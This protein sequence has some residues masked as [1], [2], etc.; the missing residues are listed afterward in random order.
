MSEEENEQ[1]IQEETQRLK[2]KA[3]EE[4]STLATILSEDNVTPRRAKDDLDSLV[5]F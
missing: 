3:K 5:D 1:L 2:D 4:A